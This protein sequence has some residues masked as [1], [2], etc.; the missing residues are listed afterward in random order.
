MATTKSKKVKWIPLGG[1]HE[2][3]KNCNALE[4]QD[5]II[6]ID[7][8]LGFPDE[9]MLGVDIVVP[10]FTYLVENMEKVKAVFITHGHE[11]HIGSIPYLLK[12]I[13]VPIYATAFTMAIL[14]RKLQEHTYPYEPTLITVKDGDVIDTDNFSVEF[15]HVNHSIAD[16]CALAIRTPAG[17][18]VHSGDFK[19]DTTPLSGEMTDL[20]RFGELGKEGVK[21]LLCESTNIERPGFTSSEKIV[22]AAL[23]RLFDQYRNKRIIIATFSSNTSRVQQIINISRQYKRK[24]AITGRSMTNVV[25]ASIELGYLDLPDNQFIELDDVEKY[26]PEQVTIITTGSQGE[27][28]SALYRMAYGIHISVTLKE[29]DIVII[30]ASAIPG[31]EKLIGNI[32]NMLITKNVPMVT[33]T[34]EAVH[35]S[36]HACQDEIKI[37]HALCKPQYV[38]PVH[39]ETR[40]LYK[41]KEI[42]EMLGEKPNNIFIMKNGDV[43]EMD[44]KTA[45]ITGE[46]QSGARMIDGGLTDVTSVVLGD[47]KKLSQEGL[48]V[49]AVSVDMVFGELIAGP[50]VVTR[51][52]IYEKDS[53]KFIE[54]LKKLAK[55]TV[56]DAL[57]KRVHDYNK[58]RTI[59]RDEI[60][61]LVYYKTKAHPVILTLITNINSNNI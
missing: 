57:Y 20:T 13:N 21:L 47:R 46:V 7:C 28:M 22:A 53:L 52:L 33:D 15:V 49:I 40:H 41:H 31:N 10:D 37:L 8:G 27:P 61:K 38:I 50:E 36:G 2:I 59:L 11:D 16:A 14:R 17:L 24:I 58:L 39:G 12:Q 51:G 35:V 9:E 26:P 34:A 4:Y 25:Q 60:S 3:G 30:S 45:K 48:V 1:L 42:G 19:I 29:T 18:I 23:E 32:Q 44:N 56:E 6:V 43:F 54:E 5:E 55:T